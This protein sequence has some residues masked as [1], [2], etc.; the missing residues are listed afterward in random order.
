MIFC[1]NGWRARNRPD[2]PSIVVIDGGEVVAHE[3]EVTLAPGAR[4]VQGA[5]FSYPN[6]DRA[7]YPDLPESATVSV[8]VD[9]EVMR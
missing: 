2:L 4:I 9:G 3:F 8:W 1:V 7:E 5:P 6:P